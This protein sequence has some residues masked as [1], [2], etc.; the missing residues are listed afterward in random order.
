MKANA[1]GVLC[2]EKYHKPASNVNIALESL[3]AQSKLPLEETRLKEALGQTEILIGSAPVGP[4]TIE[5]ILKFSNRSPHV[6]FSSTETC[7]QV[8]AAPTKMLPDDLKRVFEAGWSHR[9]H[10][11]ETVGY[12][13]GREHFPFTRVRVVKSVDPERSEVNI[14]I[15]MD[16]WFSVKLT[17]I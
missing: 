7:L 9:H 16:R 5:R 14:K 15:I 6:R 1:S 10:G 2:I 4:T 12:Y 8:M 17:F 3:S 11:E 13:I